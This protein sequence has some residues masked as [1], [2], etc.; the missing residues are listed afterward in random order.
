MKKVLVLLADG[1]E[2]IEALSV[3]DILRRAE[4]DVVT[5]GL[6][7]KEVISTRN[8]T[9]IA[10]SVMSLMS[11]D[12]FDALVLPGGEPGATTM[13]NNELVLDLVLSFYNRNKI[14]AAICAAPKVFEATGIL[15]GKRATCYPGCEAD[16]KNV[17]YSEDAVCV[18]G[19]IITSR[20]PATAMSFSY[21]ILNQLGLSDISEKL[22]E[23]MLMNYFKNDLKSY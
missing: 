16:F 6:E 13:K 9:I 2:E 8:V 12:E 5:A 23:G 4:V 18:D 15:S 14:L 20:G 17:N 7:K 11:V 10:D 3:I 19:H 22:Q 21:E 1:F